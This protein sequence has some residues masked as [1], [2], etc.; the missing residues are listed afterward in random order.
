MKVGFFEESTGVH[1]STRLSSFLFMFFTFGFDL[2]WI[3][4][5]DITDNFILLN[6]VFIVAVF[7]P[8]TISKL[9]ELKFSKL[10]E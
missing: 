4:S 5:H 10:K 1:S 3:R 8:K 9:A 2:F 7:V 6:L